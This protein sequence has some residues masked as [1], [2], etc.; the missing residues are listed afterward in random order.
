MDDD[1]KASLKRSFSIN[2]DP[3]L[4]TFLNAVKDEDRV[5]SIFR[6]FGVHKTGDGVFTFSK[7]LQ[8]VLQ[9]LVVGSNCQEEFRKF[10]YDR[11]TDKRELGALLETMERKFDAMEH[12]ASAEREYQKKVHKLVHATGKD[13]RKMLAKAAADRRRS[14]A[15]EPGAAEA[16]LQDER[17]A[18]EAQEARE[19]KEAKIA[20][21]LAAKKD[22]ERQEK[23]AKAEAAKERRKAKEAA[24]LAEA[25]AMQ[26][27]R[28]AKKLAKT[29]QRAAGTRR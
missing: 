3:A 18:K 27:A 9:S 21:Y 1:I 8:A 12:N 16:K 26:E 19:A 14:Q 15:Q 10:I 7:E 28:E 6:E 29:A 25:K 5:C 11:P 20:A 2:R 23:L 4:P 24:A 17:E 22:E 13:K